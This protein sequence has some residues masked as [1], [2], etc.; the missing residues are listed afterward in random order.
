M[1]FS[2]SVLSHNPTN[3]PIRNTVSFLGVY[4]DI[5]T[6]WSRDQIPSIPK[7]SVEDLLFIINKY[8]T[9]FDKAL[10]YNKVKQY[11]KITGLYN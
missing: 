9:K 5:I 10:Y 8:D 7:G 11:R 4:R 6:G 3:L 2:C 1:L